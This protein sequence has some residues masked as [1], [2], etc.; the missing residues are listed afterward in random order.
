MCLTHGKKINLGCDLVVYKFMT[1]VSDGTFVSPYN[2]FIWSP[3]NGG[4]YVA[5]GNPDMFTEVRASN[6][7]EMDT[8]CVLGGM[9]HSYDK[10]E[11]AVREGKMYGLTVK[12][13][14]SVAIGKFIIPAKD[15]VVYMGYDNGDKRC[16]SYA[17]R[18]IKFVGVVDVESESYKWNLSCV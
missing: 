9:F 10:L 7:D 18:R 5:G 13:P 15:N 14:Y 12:H 3:K 17:S 8:Y 11:D 6:T 16:V 2:W 1:R 4:E